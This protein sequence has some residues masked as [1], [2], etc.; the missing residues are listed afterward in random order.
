MFQRNCRRL[1]ALIN[2]F[3]DYGRVEAGAMRVDK[4]PFKVR[5]TVYDAVHTFAETAARQQ[6]DLRLDIAENVPDWQLGDP[7]RIQ[8]ILMNLVSNALKFTSRGR[9]DVRAVVA[10][11]EDP[12]QLRIEV[13]DSGPGISP[14]DQQKIFAPFTQLQNQALANLPGSGLGLTI[15]VTSALGSGSTFYF[16]VP[17]VAAG[18]RV[19][20]PAVERSVTR[21]A[22]A[23]AIRLLVAEDGED[24]R[25]LLKHFLRGEP[26]AVQF[27]ENGQVALDLITGGAEF[28]LVL[29]DLDMPVLDGY[30]ATRKIREWE[31]SA[32]IPAMPIIALSAHAV[33]DL[34]HASLDAGCNAHL[35]KP[36]ERT[37]LIDTVFRYTVAKDAVKVLEPEAPSASDGVDPDI[38]ALVPQ[39][40][41]SKWK[42]M[43]EAEGH[44]LEHD[45]EPVRRFGHNLKGTARGYGFPPLENIGRELEVAAAARQEAGIA[46]QLEQLGKFLENESVL[47]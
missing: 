1:V 8:Q 41:A 12:R 16:S 45:F 33:Q 37:V 34:V 17:L 15:G 9:V 44:L 32:G 26:V 31:A 23:G 30:A 24:N 43:Q 25:S 2:D 11:S 5:Q 39:Y 22:A 13:S 29:M 19:S 4:S 38:A 28:D 47:V 36:V 20:A 35:A 27:A 18:P 3:L 6:V 14:E 10:A 40:L 46:Q 7:L 42:Q 21:S